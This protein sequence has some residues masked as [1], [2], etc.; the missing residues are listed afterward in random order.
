MVVITDPHGHGP[1]QA[2]LGEVEAPV[3]EGVHQAEPG[4][5]RVRLAA[6]V[7]VLDR[8]APRVVHH[9]HRITVRA[10]RE[11]RPQ[12]LVSRHQSI[13]SSTQSHPV[14]TAPHTERGRHHVLRT[15][16]IQLIQEPQA[17][18]REGQPNL[19]HPRRTT[20][21]LVGRTGAPNGREKTDFGGNITHDNSLLCLVCLHISG[22]YWTP[23]L[24]ASL[25]AHYRCPIS[26]KVLDG[27]CARLCK[28]AIVDHR[29]RRPQRDSPFVRVT[30]GGTPKKGKQ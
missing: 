24:R 20:Q 18:L 17:A 23:L 14:E 3:P 27:R 12:Y 19:P 6:D 11:M 28:V 21:N 10:G 9:L 5:H 2:S 15:P 26:Q 4:L 16:R 8:H 22:A 13:Q 30:C 1:Q 29:P 25:L 7:Q